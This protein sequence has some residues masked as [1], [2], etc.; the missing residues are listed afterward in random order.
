MLI[1]FCGNNGPVDSRETVRWPDSRR[2]SWIH[3]GAN[4]RQIGQCLALALWTSFICAAIGQ[5]A[6]PLPNMSAT[7][8]LP[9]GVGLAG[10][11]TG[12]RGMED[13]ADVIFADDFEAGD[14]RQ[15]WAE[16]RDTQQAVL[17]LVDDS[18]SDARV[19][20]RS[21]KVRAT[22]GETPEAV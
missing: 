2:S 5:A 16:V 22:L 10:A 18:A 11:V 9:Q 8:R 19:G 20:R 6:E 21:L 7:S 3:H 15:K 13:S 14:F 4:M 17:S 12:D 1:P